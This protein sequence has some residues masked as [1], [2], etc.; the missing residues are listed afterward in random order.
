MK[1]SELRKL[2]R[3]SIKIVLKEY[4][5]KSRL[6]EAFVSKKLGMMWKKMGNEKSFFGGSANTMDIAWDQVPDSAFK[7]GKK[8]K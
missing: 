1:K 3:E 5:K 4:N 2:I 8:G 6:T 7:K